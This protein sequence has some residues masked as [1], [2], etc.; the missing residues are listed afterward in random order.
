M[1]SVLALSELPQADR[2]NS[3]DAQIYIYYYIY[4]YL[5]DELLNERGVVKLLAGQY[6]GYLLKKEYG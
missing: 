3:Q 6:F 2:G 1:I 5:K 4:I